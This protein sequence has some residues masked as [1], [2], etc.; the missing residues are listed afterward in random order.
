MKIFEKR[1]MPFCTPT[2]MMAA[3]ARTK[4]RVDRS[5]AVQAP[6]G[7]IMMGVMMAEASSTVCTLSCPKSDFQT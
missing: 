5:G 6:L 4:S 3:V 1:S 2:K 7:A